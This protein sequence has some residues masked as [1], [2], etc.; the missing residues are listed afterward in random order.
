MFRSRIVLLLIKQDTG[1]YCLINGQRR[2]GAV[3]PHVMSSEQRVGV[4]FGLCV[5]K[6]TEFR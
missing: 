5:N 4:L 6:S 1:R 3:V 2:Q